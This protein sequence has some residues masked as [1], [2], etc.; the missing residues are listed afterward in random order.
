VT[1]HPGG[2][3]PSQGRPH[4]RPSPGHATPWVRQH[5]RPVWH[6]EAGPESPVMLCGTV[7][8]G[9]PIVAA[10]PPAHEV[11]CQRCKS[12]GGES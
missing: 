3:K 11:T 5:H 10:E 2:A 4:V 9:S 7:I 6:H 8:T 12:L 1:D